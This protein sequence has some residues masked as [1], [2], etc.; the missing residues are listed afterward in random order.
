MPSGTSRMLTKK[1]IIHYLYLLIFAALVLL[2]LLGINKFAPSFFILR[3]IIIL[4]AG[5]TIISLMAMLIFFSGYY[6]N[7]EKSVFVT[8]IGIGVKMVLS[9][10]LALIFFLVLKNRATGS[11]ILF[12]VLYLGFTVFVVLTFLS[13][14]KTKPL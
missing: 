6:K 8:L 7:A 4:I 9:L 14:L 11:V 3:N 5:F 13:V 12:F 10:I 1:A 2:A